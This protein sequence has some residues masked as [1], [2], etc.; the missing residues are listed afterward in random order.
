[1]RSA[2]IAVSRAS[3]Q[4]CT[5]IVYL[6]RLADKTQ[7][8][9]PKRAYARREFRGLKDLE[10]YVSCRIVVAKKGHEARVR[11]RILAHVTLDNVGIVHPNHARAI[12]SKFHDA[13]SLINRE[14][15]EK[16]AVE[17]SIALARMLVRD[18]ERNAMTVEDL[19]RLYMRED[20]DFDPARWLFGSRS[21]RKDP[22][23]LVR[24]ITGTLSELSAPTAQ[25][26]ID[27]LDDWQNKARRC[28]MNAI[29]GRYR[30]MYGWCRAVNRH[31]MEEE[32][33]VR[34]VV[35]PPR[36][37]SL[38]NI[39]QRLHFNSSFNYVLIDFNR[40]ASIL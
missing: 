9:T 29:D 11:Q 16:N 8:G 7:Q 26:L 13:P 23:S 18:I 35:K 28:Q 34:W 32:S 22:R 33:N 24:E 17:W 20:S 19:V 31:A 38:R 3:T 2:G 39:S 40:A 4:T 6:N 27:L 25:Q 5:H 12:C 21:T 15:G 36:S 30:R 10:R 37:R 1:V 14:P